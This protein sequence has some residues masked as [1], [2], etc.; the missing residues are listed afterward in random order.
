MINKIRENPVIQIDEMVK[1]FNKHYKDKKYSRSWVAEKMNVVSRLVKPRKDCLRNSDH[2]YKRYVY[3]KDMVE[4]KLFNIWFSDESMCELRWHKEGKV[5]VCFGDEIPERPVNQYEPK[6]MVWGA[7]CRKGKTELLVIDEGS[8]TANLYC[9]YIR[10]ELYERVNGIY[11]K[12]KWKFQQDNAKVHTSNKVMQMFKDLNIR[13]V[14]HPPKSPDLNPI[15]YVWSFIKEKVE[16]KK[17]K[18]LDDAQEMMIEI[19]DN[20]KLDLLNAYISHFN[21]V[22]KE[23]IQQYES[24]TCVA[25]V[26]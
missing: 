2:E 12:N 10:Y 24:G 17:F 5:R 11:G 25:K 22:C 23:I 18:E 13:L 26:Y 21:T 14:D 7:I 20:I 4:S 6:I 1:L 16:K 19:W 9:D 3:A 8:M 15:E